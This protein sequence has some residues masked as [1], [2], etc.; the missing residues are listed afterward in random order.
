MVD[1]NSTDIEFIEAFN[2]DLM[3]SRII[4]IFFAYT[5]YIS[6]NNFTNRNEAKKIHLFR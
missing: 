2:S 4:W 5:E 6:I 1:E 3:T